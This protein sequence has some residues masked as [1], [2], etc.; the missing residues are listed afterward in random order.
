[1]WVNL[2]T[3]AVGVIGYLVG[4]DMIADNASL[5][6]ILVAVQGV[7]NIGLRFVTT[8]AIV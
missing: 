2:A 4:Q 3:L 6:A 8:K 1:M 5:V 7:V